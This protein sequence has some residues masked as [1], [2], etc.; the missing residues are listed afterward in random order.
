MSFPDPHHDHAHCTAEL[1]ARAARTC[2]RRGSRLTAQ[3]REVLACV[4]QSHAAVGAYDIIERMASHGPRPAPITVY[5]ALDF[6]LAHGL[7]HKIESRNAF[8]ACS[9]AHDSEPSAFLICEGCGTVAELEAPA[10][11]ATLG[12]A[13]TGQGFAATRTV[14]EMTGRCRACRRES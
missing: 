8:V 4:G 6:L 14:I 7:V 13:A 5:R 9:L 10:A 12:A 2:D 3:R 1:I 11:L